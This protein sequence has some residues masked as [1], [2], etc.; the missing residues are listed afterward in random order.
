MSVSMSITLD[1]RRMKKKTRKY[2][3]KL[4]V[5]CDSEPQ[6]YQTIFDLTQEE[7]KSLSAA[8]VL[9]GLRT[10]REQLK[11]IKQESEKVAFGLDPFSYQEFEKEFIL[12]NPFFHQR[13]SLKG[14]TVVPS[15]DSYGSDYD[16][17]FPIFKLP[18]PEPFTILDTFLK[19]IH[20]LLGEGR[21]RTAA[22][23]QTSYTI[24]SKFRGNVKFTEIGVPYLK[25]FEQWMLDQ[26]YSITTVG[27]Y[28]RCLRAM[29]NEAIFRGIIRREKCYPFGR[30]QYQCPL[31]RNRKKALTL[32]EVEKIY[33]YKPIC[34]AEQK[35]KDFWLFSYLA[36]GINPTDIAH[37]RFKNVEDGYITFCRSKTENATRAAPKPITFFITEDLEQI[38]NYWGN[39]KIAPNN[40][41]FPIL[42]HDI[43]PLRKVELIELFV[44]SI[45]DW[46]G[47]IR[48]KL[49]ITKSVTTYV[50]R[51]TFST[52]L[53]RSGVSTE[54]IQESLGHTDIR[55]TENYLDSFEKEVKREFSGK[56]TAFKWK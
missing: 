53:K 50:A 7:F 20:K 52:V 31:S 4:L 2:P 28:T 8:R 11:Q 27:I 12:N 17:R 43:S 16:R 6:R 47:K 32:D 45:N 55:T 46:M 49:G 10:I 42:E 40:Y 1:T 39:K 19:Y 25:Q 56:L 44:Q 36:N 21:I 48:K 33:Y 35:A 38:I 23:Y 54:F 18:T 41:L 26:E 3:V 5:T 37:L 24:I 13:K 51:H 29:F 15:Y 30:R 9:D 22:S 14:K 34:E